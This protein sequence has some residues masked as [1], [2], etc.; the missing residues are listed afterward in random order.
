MF[1]FHC[2]DSVTGVCFVPNTEVLWVAA[3]GSINY[4]DPKSGDCVCLCIVR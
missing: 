2:I 4:Y 3:G 1:Q